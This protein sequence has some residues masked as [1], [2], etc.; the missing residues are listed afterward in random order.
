MTTKI[1]MKCF[2]NVTQLVATIG[3]INLLEFES[4]FSNSPHFTSIFK[5]CESIH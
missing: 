3:I 4:K 5:M 2:M 1:L